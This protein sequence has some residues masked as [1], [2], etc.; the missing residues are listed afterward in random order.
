MNCSLTVL[1]ERRF[2]MLGNWTA[3]GTQSCDAWKVRLQDGFNH[4]MW[5]QLP[6]RPTPL[7]A[8]RIILL[9]SKYSATVLKTEVPMSLHHFDSM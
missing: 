9:S 7:W 1:D 6:N 3:D 4:S 5:H 2:I 8:N